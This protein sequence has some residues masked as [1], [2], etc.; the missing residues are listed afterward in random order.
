MIKEALVKWWGC[1]NTGVQVVKK[2][3]EEDSEIIYGLI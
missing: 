2:G 1:A 3:K